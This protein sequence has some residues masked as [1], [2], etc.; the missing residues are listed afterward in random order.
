M[1]TLF[2]FTLAIIFGGLLGAAVLIVGRVWVSKPAVAQ[3]Q[4]HSPSYAVPAP[5]VDGRLDN[6]APPA[7]PC[8]E[9]VR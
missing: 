4:S 1:K 8:C 5:V 6:E 2:A 9:G 3:W 7:K